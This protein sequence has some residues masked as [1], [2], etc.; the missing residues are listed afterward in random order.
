VKS[1]KVVK[2]HE[3]QYSIWPEERENPPGWTD[4]GVSG[5]KDVCLAFIERTWKDMTPRSLRK[6]D[7]KITN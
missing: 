3:H 6:P 5:P 7:Q 2:N 1:Y 4:A